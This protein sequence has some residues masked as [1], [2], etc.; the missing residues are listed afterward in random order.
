[1]VSFFVG[2]EQLV[3]TIVPIIIEKCLIVCILFC[4]TGLSRPIE[5]NV[6]QIYAVRLYCPQQSI[7]EKLYLKI[8]VF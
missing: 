1:M 8:N 3:S 2:V 7:P 4:L 6:P 5:P